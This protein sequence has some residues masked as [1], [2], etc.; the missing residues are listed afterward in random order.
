MANTLAGN[1][2][3]E[4]R[5]YS[6]ARSQL[7]VNITHFKIGAVTGG[8]ATDAEWLAEY[9]ADI[10]NAWK[11]IM[12]VNAELLGYAVQILG[13]SQSKRPSIWDKTGAGVGDISG[14]M[15]P[16]QTCGLITKLTNFVGRSNRGRMYIPFPSESHS[17]ATGG[18]AGAYQ[19][20]MVACS[21]AAIFGGTLT[22]AGGTAA[23]KPI[24]LNQG[25]LSGPD[26][27][28]LRWNLK[29]ATQRR[30]SDYGRPNQV[31]PEL[32]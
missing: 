26:I 19:T 29:W 17:T 24:V 5:I 4:L 8:S 20:L 6:M 16:L 32:L 3:L 14:D 25:F 27:T 21:N 13:G 1:D 7:A 23:F 2:I 9:R 31:P 12:N 18:V 15:L 22:G 11:G 10:A 30:R 28:A